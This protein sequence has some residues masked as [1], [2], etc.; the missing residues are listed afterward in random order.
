MIREATP[1]DSPRIAEIHVFAWRCAYKEFIPM[2]FLINEMT[3]KSREKKFHEYLSDVNN[4]DETYVYEE[5]N[6]VKG[7]LTMGDCRD[8]DKTNETFELMGIYIDPLF[9]RQHIGTQFV[10]YCIKNAVERGKKEIT[11]WVFEKNTNSIAFYKKMGFELD[12]KT[13]LRERYK[14]N[15]IRMRIGL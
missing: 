4:S 1:N 10:D 15:I 14:E 12:G 7:F 6:I 9:Q 3:V 2:D 13:E 8:D 5:S 11:L